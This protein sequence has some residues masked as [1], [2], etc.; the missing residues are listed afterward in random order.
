M[1]A[2]KMLQF[3]LPAA[4]FV[5]IPAGEAQGFTPYCPPRA[6]CH[7]GHEEDDGQDSPRAGCRCGEEGDGREEPTGQLHTRLDWEVI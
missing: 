5:R 7:I 3:K 4:H 6:C 1:L 2:E